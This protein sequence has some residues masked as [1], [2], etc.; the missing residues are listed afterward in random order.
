MKH[1]LLLIQI[2]LVIFVFN[3]ASTK[4]L[5]AEVKWIKLQTESGE[6]ISAIYGYPDNG[7][8]HP[9]VIYN[10]GVLVRRIGYKEA[11]NRDYKNRDYDVK[12]FVEA[13]VESGFVA[14]APIREYKRLSTTQ[15]KQSGGRISK[16]AF[17]CGDIKTC[18]EAIKEG[19]RVIKSAIQFLKEQPN[20]ADE[21]I[22]IIG[23][24]EGGLITLWSVFDYKDL[25]AIV[26]MSPSNAGKS[27]QF[28]FKEAVKRTEAITSPVFITLGDSD[29]RKIIKNCTNLLIPEMKELNKDIEYKIDYIGPHQWFKKV[30]DEYWNDIISFLNKHLK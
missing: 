28:N 13:L 4:D 14:I 17:G 20:V 6:T 29:K 27:P 2:I 10:H 1:L 26:L 18:T 21:R 7:G 3:I 25:K 5:K 19:L 22:G 16:Q 9:A 23:F 8:K 12:D 11:A 30:R 15:W 24:G